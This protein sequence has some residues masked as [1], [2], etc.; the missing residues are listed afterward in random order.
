VFFENISC[1]S[2]RRGLLL[3]GIGEGRV[4]VIFEKTGCFGGSPETEYIV[5]TVVL[6]ERGDLRAQYMV[7]SG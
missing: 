5:S 4:P 7:V 1:K 2:W 6:D 3:G